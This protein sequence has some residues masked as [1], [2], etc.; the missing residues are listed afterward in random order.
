MSLFG[1]MTSGV[2]GL[3]TQST[4]M[5]AISDNITNVNTIG[6]KNTTVNFQ[7]LVTKQASATSF[8]AG[9]IQSRPRSANDVQ[10]LLQAT[11]SETDF[12]VSGAGYMVVNETSTPA[13]DGAFAFTRAG[14][15][16][17]D[18]QGYLRNTAG[19]YLQGW[20]T[21]AVGNVVLPSTS[22]ATLP[23]QNIISND[24]LETVNLS[25]VV[26]TATET[27]SIALGANLPA[28]DAPGDS[29]TINMQVF[30][31]LGDTHD[32]S[33]VFT[34][35]QANQWELT[36]AP[37]TGTSVLH[38][39]DSAGAIYQSVG[40]LEF[41]AAPG[42]GESITIDDGV[43]P[44]TYTF[45]AGV[46][47]VG[48]DDIQ[49]GGQT[50]AAIVNSLVAA[51]NADFPSVADV[52]PGNKNALILTGGAANLAVDPTAVT[53]AII[54]T[55]A[56]TVQAKANAGPAVTFGPDG[57]PRSF[58]VSE[59]GITNFENGAADMDDTDLDTDGI[60]D[61]A[62]ISLDFGT[63][64]EADGLSQF[65][66]E[67][68][69]TFIQQDGARYGTFTGITV[70][71]DGVM[72]ALFDNGEQ[73][74]I[75]KLPIATFTNPNGL[76]AQSG[77]VWNVTETS[78]DPTLRP[79]NSGPGGQIAQSSLESSTVDLGQEFTNMIMVQ[80]AYSAST[81]IISSVDDMLEELVHL[82]R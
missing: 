66:S 71:P 17:E 2:S 25:R 9:G 11:A 63:V 32:L 56:Y 5:A 7:S 23:N 12:A 70:S 37:P 27:S 81:K 35:K 67:F 78:G 69:T 3:S 62:R 49:V 75:Y 50:L 29:H 13:G 47:A 30:D 55:S 53:S 40:Q 64:N 26:G 73:R 65:G 39:Y 58:N 59:I 14:S 72:T 41:T 15:F 60:V 1:A 48:S 6:Y 57:L 74:A 18:D 28:L 68:S 4:A 54:Q 52:K 16:F 24:F 46:P 77:N 10:G 43:A 76:Q 82:K 44:H 61:V 31:T 80:R 45:I 34:K 42:V 33:L 22:S 21:D 19:Y 36:A 51:I 20:P 79:A 38:F 8:A